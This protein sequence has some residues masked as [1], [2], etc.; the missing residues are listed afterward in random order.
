FSLSPGRA[1]PGWLFVTSDGHHILALWRDGGLERYA[2]G[3]DTDAGVSVTLAESLS[4]EPRGEV[5]SAAMLLGGQPLLVGGASGMVRGFAAARDPTSPAPDGMRLVQSSEF[6]AGQSSV[7]GLAM[8]ERDRVAGAAVQDGSVL[9]RHM[10]SG[11]VV[12]R[13]TGGGGAMAF[14]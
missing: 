11:K 13:V 10:T 8:G 9:V 2:T 7:V 4:T 14:S 3:V 12:A 6:R 5:T 1:R